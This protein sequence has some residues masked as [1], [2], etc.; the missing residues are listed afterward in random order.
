MKRPK[1][2]YT[3]KEVRSILLELRNGKWPKGFGI[4]ADSDVLYF[5][6]VINAFERKGVVLDPH[7]KPSSDPA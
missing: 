4:H 3:Y 6:N 7:R 5:V 2:T 1:A